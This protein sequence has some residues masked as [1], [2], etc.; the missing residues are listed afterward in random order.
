MYLWGSLCTLCLL[1]CQAIVTI[2]YSGLLLCLCDVFSA[3]SVYAVM[4]K[5]TEPNEWLKFAR[6]WLCFI[7]I[8]AVNCLCFHSGSQL[9]VFVLAVNCL[10]FHS[11]SQLSLFSFWHSTVFVFILAVSCL[12]F[13]S[14]TRLSLFSFWQSAV[15]VF[16]LALNLSLFSFWQSTVYVFILAV[17]CLC[18]HSGSQLSMFS[19]WQSTVSVFILALDLSLFSFWH[20]TVSV[21]ILALNCLCFHSGTQLSLFSFWHSTVSDYLLTDK[22]PWTPSSTRCRRVGHRFR[23]WLNRL[24]MARARRRPTVGRC[25]W[26]SARPSFAIFSRSTNVRHMRYF[27]SWTWSFIAWRKKNHFLLLLCQIKT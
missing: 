27:I 23:R 1:A 7:F 26:L 12:C 9:S 16:I 21:F 4:S 8:L 19:F 5:N 2:G 18:F 13:H 15:S 22:L 14:G 6:V 25:R 17:N 24:Q 11:G 20:S 3:L 10:C